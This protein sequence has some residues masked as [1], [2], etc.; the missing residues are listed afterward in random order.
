MAPDLA[1][2]I[3]DWLRSLAG[4]LSGDW[5]LVQFGLMAA[6]VA[7]AFL[8]NLW[9]EPRLEAQI[10]RIRNRPSLLRLLAAALRRLRWLLAAA[11]MWAV[12]LVMRDVTWPSRSYLIGIAA[13]LTTAW[14]LIAIGS[15]V[16]RNRTLSRIVAL[17]AW[18]VVALG[19]L[20]VRDDIAEAL[21]FHAVQ[22]GAFRLSGLVVVK[23]LA[24]LALLLWAAGFTGDLIERSVRDNPDITPS[25]RVLIAK[26]VKFC[27]V[28]AAVVVTL[29]AVGID[30]TALTLVS[31]AIGLGLGFGLQRVVSNLVSGVIILAD[32]SIKPGDVIEL[33]QTFGWVRSL[34]ARF[35]SVITRDGREYLIPNED[36][37]TQRVINWSFTDDL[38]R[39]DV[40]FRVSFDCDPHAVR[41]LGVEAAAGV[42]RVSADP[43]PVCHIEE[44]GEFSLNFILRFWIRDPANGI[45]NVRGEVLLA[46]WDALK[47]N[48]VSVPY[49]RREVTV[50]P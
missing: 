20:G 10:R 26:L 35:V 33:G 46:V 43:R 50:R 2:A 37:V 39:L 34:R 6:A 14:A 45:T 24:L 47:A 7:A 28:V 18:I 44:F 30:L 29:T 4:T 22:L 48:G 31:G 25:L 42:A 49:P 11:L 13:S 9:L 3:G 21:D 36:F 8:V 32:R 16:I 40:R 1:G 5:A 27:L 12:Y 19:V 17:A 41:R 15:R 38:V 23:G